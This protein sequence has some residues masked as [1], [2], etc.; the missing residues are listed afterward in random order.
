M[1][2][3]F[4][5]E[6]DAAPNNKTETHLDRR[7]FIAAAG[8]ASLLALDAC[9]G[10]GG[11]APA[12]VPPPPSSPNWASLQGVLSGSVLLPGAAGFAAAAPVFNAAYDATVPQAVVRCATT[13]DVAMAL[14]FAREYGVAVTARSGGH[15]YTGNSA[16]TGMLIDVGALGS[17]V[18]GSGTATIGAGAKLVDIYD[19]LS[20]QGVCIPSGTCPTIGIAGITQGGGI[21][22]VDRAYGL[23]C[24]HLVSAQVVLAD[25]SIVTCDAATHADLFWALRGGGGGNFGIVTSMTFDTFATQDVTSFSASFAWADA[26]NVLAAW[27]A[28]P[29][30]LPDTV[31]SGLVLSDTQMIQVAGIV[32]GSESDFAPIWAQFLAAAGAAPTSQTIQLE[33]FRDAMLASCYAMTVSQCHL[34]SETSDGLVSR[35]AFAATSD[36]FD[37]ALPT[38]GIQALLAAVSAQ[39]GTGLLVIMDLMG[40]AIA[41]VAPDATAFVHRNALFSAQYYIQSGLGVPDSVVANAR[42]VVSGMRAA[43][44]AWSSGEAYQNYLDPNLANWQSAYYGANYARLVQVKAAYDPTQ[45]FKPAQGIPPQ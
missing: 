10:G 13:N 29:Q 17:I 7:R 26:A 9:G 4:P 25:S 19:Q 22:V 43:M 16:T 40:G 45:M 8:S 21:G 23:T 20:T 15:G 31:W 28:W 38:A 39:Q 18:V 24:D 34:G 35:T 1:I 33:S 3:A 44:S 36:F 11:G 27:Q 30:T 12:P 2:A 32:L 6:P 14:N 42:G 37:A 41:R 5:C